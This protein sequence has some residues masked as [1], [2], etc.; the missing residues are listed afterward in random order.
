MS[1]A[2]HPGKVH[3]QHCNSLE[4]MGQSTNRN[5][6]DDIGSQSPA[7]WHYPGTR[8]SLQFTR[9]KMVAARGKSAVEVN[10]SMSSARELEALCPAPPPCTAFPRGPCSSLQGTGV[11]W[12]S[13]QAPAPPRHRMN[14]HREREKK[15]PCI[16]TQAPS[17]D[18]VA[19]RGETERARRDPPKGTQS[20]P[21]QPDASPGLWRFETSPPLLQTMAWP[22]ALP[23][24]PQSCSHRRGS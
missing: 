5:S 14:S 8:C 11:A 22:G 12:A 17:I 13:S 20:S 16:G 21:Q 10:N 2:R 15:I 3:Q 6:P 18:N 4:N 1:Q 19:T 7:M 9:K 24:A 23:R